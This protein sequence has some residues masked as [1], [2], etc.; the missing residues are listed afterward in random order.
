MPQIYLITLGGFIL[1]LMPNAF[2]VEIEYY[3]KTISTP[4]SSSTT[5]WVDVPGA[6][7]TQG[8]FTT[9]DKYLIIVNALQLGDSSS[10][11]YELQMEHGAVTGADEE[12]TDFT[13]SNMNIETGAATVYYPYTWFT[14]WTA[15]ASEGIQLEMKKASNTHTVDQITITIINLDD[16]LTENTDWFYSYDATDV[17]IPSDLSWVGG[18]ADSSAEIEFIPGNADDD[19]LVMG[20][21]RANPTSAS[22]NIYTALNSTGTVNAVQPRWSQEGEDTTNDRWVMYLFRVFELGASQQ[23]FNMISRVDGATASQFDDSAIFALNLENFEAHSSAWTVAQIA[24]GAGTD[25]STAVEM[26]TSDI[27][28]G[29]AGALFLMSQHVQDSGFLGS[30]NRQLLDGG[31]SPPFQSS[32]FYQI[33]QGYD[34]TDE[35]AWAVHNVN[36]TGSSGTYTLS[37]EAVHSSAQQ[38]EDRTNVAFTMELAAAAGSTVTVSDEFAMEDQDATATIMGIVTVSDE[39][40]FEDQ[41]T[42]NSGAGTVTVSDEFAFEDQDAT[43]FSDTVT[44]SDEFAF[45]DTT[46]TVEGEAIVFNTIVITLNSPLSDRL[47]GSFSLIC[48]SNSTFTGLLP[49]GTFVC[50]DMS[51]FF[52]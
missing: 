47:G 41:G 48:P 11:T 2:G 50:T 34:G 22:V 44:V 18:I 39:F 25:F 5:S 40:A 35:I 10:A 16:G 27:T 15:I 51:V 24:S 21:N 30:K 14:V 7:I 8:N 32:N 49:N 46:E 28:T 17:T 4:Y 13:E 45:E 29:Q 9:G 3:S 31:D 6:Y 20:Y 12:V 36:V 37:H 26:Q 38:R 1:F 33:I 19:W 52:P 42:D 43:A 23:N